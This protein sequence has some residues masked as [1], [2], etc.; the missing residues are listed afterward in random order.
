[1]TTPV[2]PPESP[3]HE[4]FVDDFGF[5]IALRRVYEEVANERPLDVGPWGFAKPI[6]TTRRQRVINRVRM[7]GDRIVDA[8]SVLRGRAYTRNWGEND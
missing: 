2:P 7:Y 3:P 4:P 5:T 8:W 6:T 1:M